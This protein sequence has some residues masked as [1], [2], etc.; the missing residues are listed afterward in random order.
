MSTAMG[1]PSTAPRPANDWGSIPIGYTRQRGPAPP[2]QGPG[3]APSAFAE[4]AANRPDVD[5]L[6]VGDGPLR[7]ELEGLWPALGIAGRVR[8]LGVRDDVPEILGAVDVFAHD[9]DQ[10]GRR[11]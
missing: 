10:R 5:L 7:G 3:H 2:D 4:V 6:L 9:F 8:F 11:R 1:L